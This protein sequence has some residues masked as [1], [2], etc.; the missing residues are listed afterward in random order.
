V[1]VEVTGAPG[2]PLTR[3]AYNLGCPGGR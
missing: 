3:W 2:E 1:T